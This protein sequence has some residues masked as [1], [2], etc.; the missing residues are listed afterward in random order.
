MPTLDPQEILAPVVAEVQA[1]MPAIIQT[2]PGIQSLLQAQTMEAIVRAR[3]ERIFNES[4]EEPDQD[5]R[6]ALK[7]EMERLGSRDLP[8]ALAVVE[9]AKC[10]IQDQLDRELRVRFA[11]KARTAL[12]AAGLSEAEAT[13]AMGF[14]PA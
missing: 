10:D 7:I 13:A 14:F 5:R 2:L 12:L 3:L 8:A 6:E 11:T 9:Q 4:A 1:E